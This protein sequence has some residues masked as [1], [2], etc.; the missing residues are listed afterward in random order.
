MNIKSPTGKTI[1][2]KIVQILSLVKN[3]ILKISLPSIIVGKI[4]VL[5]DIDGEMTSFSK[6]GLI[7]IDVV[8]KGSSGISFN[9][10]KY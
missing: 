4:F 6:F 5:S 1:K 3:K 2:E 7:S 9:K 8:R 10:R